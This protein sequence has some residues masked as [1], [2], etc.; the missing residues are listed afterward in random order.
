MRQCEFCLSPMQSTGSIEDEIHMLYKIECKLAEV[1]RRNALP[2]L[3]T[4][5]HTKCGIVANRFIIA[6]MLPPP[7]IKVS[8]KDAVEVQVATACGNYIHKIYGTILT[9][10]KKSTYEF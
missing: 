4:L 10:K 6:S 8:H 9:F 5:L 3:T 1:L 2:R 7:T